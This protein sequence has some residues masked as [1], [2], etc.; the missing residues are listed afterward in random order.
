M[1]Q[2]VMQSD[3]DVVKSLYAF[4]AAGDLEGLKSILHPEVVIL[5]AASLPYGGR[6]DGK[7]GFVDLVMALGANWDNFSCTEFEYYTGDQGVVVIFRFQATARATG[8]K[9]DQRFTELWR[10]RDGLVSYLEPFYYDT[11]SIRNSLGHA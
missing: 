4:V 8:E 10:V 6:Y 1:V 2:D 9:V 5:E 7:D 3:L 11:H